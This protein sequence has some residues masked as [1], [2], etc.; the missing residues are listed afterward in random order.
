M[1]FILDEN[2]PPVIIHKDGERW[3]LSFNGSNPE[4]IDAI[5]LS[6]ELYFLLHEKI[7]NIDPNLFYKTMETYSHPKL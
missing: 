3:L 4:P 2:S 5:E 7:M 1:E 6:K